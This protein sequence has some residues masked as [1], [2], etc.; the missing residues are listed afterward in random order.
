[1]LIY[2]KN[3]CNLEKYLRKFDFKFLENENSKSDDV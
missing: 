2:F 1:M 3:S